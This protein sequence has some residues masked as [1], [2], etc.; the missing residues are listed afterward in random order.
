MSCREIGVGFEESDASFESLAK[1]LQH[2]AGGSQALI[3]LAL[4][5]RNLICSVFGPRIRHRFF[6][7]LKLLLQTNILMVL[8]LLVDI[9]WLLYELYDSKK[10]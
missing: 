2:V 9:L 8:K 5:V 3:F 6:L 7:V 1:F 4:L 10:L